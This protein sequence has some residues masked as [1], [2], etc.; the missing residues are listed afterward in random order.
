MKGFFI[1]A[2]AGGVAMWLYGDQIREY[3]DEMTSGVRERAAAKLEGAADRLQSVAESVEGG[4]S[5]AS[6]Q[7]RRAI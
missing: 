4:L 5:D 7:A 2:I 1:G 6:T 3:V